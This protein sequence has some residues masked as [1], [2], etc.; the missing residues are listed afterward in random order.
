VDL[1]LLGGNVV[2]MDT[3]RPRASALAVQDGKIVALGASE[4]LARLVDPGTEV[5]QLSGRAVLPGFVDP[6]NHFSMTVFEPVSVD[7]RIPPL[8]G[9]P[10]VLDAIAA[11]AAGAL[12]GRWIWGLG[13]SA[14]GGIA[15]SQLTRGDLDE[16]A[17]NNPVC[18]IDSSVHACYANSAALALA[19]IDRSTPDPD[20]GRILRDANGEAD[21]PLWERAMNGV[22]QQS[23]AA[24]IDYYGEDAVAD[25]VHQNAMRHLAHGITSVGDANVMPES[26]T[27]YRL[28]DA[29]GKLPIVM[30]QMRAGD[31]FFAPPEKAAHGAFSDDDVSDRLRGGTVKIF[32][33]PVFPE[34]AGLRIHPDGRREQLGRPYYTQAQADEL[35]LAAAERGLQV[36]IHCLGTW[37]IEQALNA[38]EG[39]LR[40][41]PASDVRHRI[42]HFS[43]PTREHMQRSSSL[44]ITAVHQPPFLY[45]FGE[46]A[47]ATLA[48][49]GIDAPP[50]A[51]R[52]MLDAGMSVAASS[53]FPCAPLEPLIGLY[54]IVSR[55]TRS[56]VIVA[57][58][59][60][61][62]AMEALR[63]YT[64]GGARAM[65]RD[66]EVGTLEVGK[67]A[68]MVVLSHDPTAVAPE[69]IRE[70][71]VQ[72]TY[73]DGKR[74]YQL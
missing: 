28:A 7:C 6:H 16:V 33:D 22:H 66:H 26:A 69:F 21:G 41:F 67:R 50:A 51:M 31:Q 64:L 60:A 63:L 72:Q 11:A 3:S 5:V 14:R 46:R 20:G 44:G 39:A 73:V 56:G 27:M 48:E 68:D 70:I 2:T 9:K 32:M 10:G 13:Y 59:E 23:M 35:V 25:L 4:E 40:K 65:N 62:D 36:A 52:S 47:A 53:D 17:P 1:V 49:R 19:G 42:E 54:S 34:N 29:R 12:P 24:L 61:L 45:T 74:L 38:L 18:V 57:P 58:E 43:A 8:A 15:P 71:V 37:A 55:R 30:H